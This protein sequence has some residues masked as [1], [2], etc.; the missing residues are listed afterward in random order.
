MGTFATDVW[1][2][3]RH[4]VQFNGAAQEELALHAFLRGLAPEP[5]C[6]HVRLAML[7][8]LNKAL[9]EAEQLEV[10]LS[11]QSTQQRAPML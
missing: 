2:H 3:A 8:S 4:G 11:I 6:Q 1:L 7:Q 9:H 5:L 10:V